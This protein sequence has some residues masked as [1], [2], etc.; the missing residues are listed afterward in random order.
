MDMNDNGVVTFSSCSS[1]N[2]L[3]D[4]DDDANDRVIVQV[5]DVHKYILQFP[6]L[7]GN[8]TDDEDETDL[9]PGKVTPPVSQQEPVDIAGNNN[10]VTLSDVPS[11]QSANPES[12]SVSNSIATNQSVDAVS[13]NSILPCAVVVDDDSAKTTKDNDVCAASSVVVESSSSSKSN[14][15]EHE[16]NQESLP[17]PVEQ[18]SDLSLQGKDVADQVARAKD[19]DLQYC[20]ILSKL[21]TDSQTTESKDNQACPGSETVIASSDHVQGQSLPEDVEQCESVQ[22]VLVTKPNEL[23]TLP[24]EKVSKAE[25]SLT[26]V[27]ELPTAAQQLQVSVEQKTVP[28]VAHAIEINEQLTVE[29]VIKTVDVLET[30]QQSADVPTPVSLVSVSVEQLSKIIG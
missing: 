1:P 20:S 5:P 27:E 26:C 30:D 17:K 6:Q 15:S 24:V 29:E 14:D 8:I 23:S 16:T 28:V 12:V 13:S 9:A 10:D 22:P 21:S 18:D 11:S 4:D 2:D 19:G 7:D 25:Q 3:G